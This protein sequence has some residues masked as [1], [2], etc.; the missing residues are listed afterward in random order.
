MPRCRS[1]VVLIAAAGLTACGAFDRDPPSQPTFY[2]SMAQAGA[3]LD[4]AAA[5]SMIS[6]YRQNNGL[7]AL[8]LDPT[9]MRLAEEQARA[10]AG[11]D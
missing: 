10:M 7:P 4:A 9:L 3:E 8:T 2:R 6:G 5:Q 11:R 1:L